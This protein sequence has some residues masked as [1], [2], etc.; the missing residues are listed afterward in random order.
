[1]PQKSHR[2]LICVVLFF[3]I[4]IIA[5]WYSS[6]SFLLLFSTSLLSLIL[7]GIF[8]KKVNV[9]TVL[10]LMT[11]LCLGMLW[12]H[13][14]ILIH[15]KDIARIARFYRQKPMMIKGVIVSDVEERNFFR[16]KKTVFTLNVKEVKAPWGWKKHKGKI[17]VNIFKE[18]DLF[19]GDYVQLTGKLHRPFNFSKGENFSYRSYLRNKGI[20]FIL[21]VKKE[22]KF[23]ILKRNQNNQVRALSLKLRNH[24]KMVLEQHLTESETGIMKAILLGD[25]SKIPKHVRGLFVRTGT[26]HILAISGLHI[27]V[28]AGLFLMFLKLFPIQ[29]NLQLLMTIFLV[30]GY[31][32]LTGGRPSVVR[33]TIMVTVILGGFIAER[34]ADS[35]NTLSLAAMVILLFNPLNLFDIG[36]QLSFICVGSII[37]FYPMIRNYENRIS[38]VS[39]TPRRVSRY[40]K[41]SINISV[42]VWFGAAGII[43]YYFNIITPVTVFAN[44]IVVPMIS[45]V[46]ALGFGL[47][48]AGSIFLPLAV[49]FAMCLKVALN[50]MVAIIFLFDKVPYAYFYIKTVNHWY[51]ILYYVVLCLIF[52]IFCKIDKVFRV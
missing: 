50:I 2:P 28:V 25:R 32:F 44:L 51:V 30:I 14:N 47:L 7:A 45:V 20:Q 11:F 35:L 15:Q 36:F 4:G 52:K 42:S 46:V 13:V 33:A 38:F 37:L 3:G 27:G 43:A 18:T 49:M 8:Y 24:L 40:F 41:D 29:R 22:E 39:D 34:E 21:S 19:Y 6:L 12:T 9:S 48:L 10:I 16:T 23:L 31:A 17:L 1:M 5:G 26:A